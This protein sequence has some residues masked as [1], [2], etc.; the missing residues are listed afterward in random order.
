MIYTFHSC[1]VHT[2]HNPTSPRFTSTLNILKDIAYS[3]EWHTTSGIDPRETR[4][5]AST[6]PL[7]LQSPPASIKV[8]R[9]TR[10]RPGNSSRR[11]QTNFPRIS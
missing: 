10:A 2:T 8:R 3:L 5:R 4:S 1:N 6:L 9:E 7:Y 11:R